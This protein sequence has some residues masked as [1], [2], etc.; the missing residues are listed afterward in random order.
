MADSDP[1]FTKDNGEIVSRA[2]LRRRVISGLSRWRRIYPLEARR[3][4][5]AATLDNAAW[6]RARN[7]QTVGSIVRAVEDV[8]AEIVL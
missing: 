5:I 1:T 3:A 2:Y 7:G 6:M 4:A 8:A